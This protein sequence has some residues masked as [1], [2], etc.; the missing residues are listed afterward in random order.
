[1]NFLECI[2]IL[3]F[4]NRGITTITF[5]HHITLYQELIYLTLRRQQRC[6]KSHLEALSYHL[7]TTTVGISISTEVCLAFQ[8]PRGVISACSLG[9]KTNADYSETTPLAVQAW[10]LVVARL[11]QRERMVDMLFESR[12]SFQESPVGTVQRNFYWAIYWQLLVFAGGRND[13][14]LL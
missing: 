7:L 2:F 1:M 9:N 5:Q 6:R 13:K 8:L 10:R 4:L 11:E 12:D 3:H 14:P